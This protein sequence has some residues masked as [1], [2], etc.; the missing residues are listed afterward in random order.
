MHEAVRDEANATGQEGAGSAVHSSGGAGGSGKPTRHER[1][2][3][4]RYEWL[5]IL[6]D[7][8]TALFFIIGSVLFFSPSTVY[9]GTWLFLIG[10]CQMIIGPFIRMFNKLHVRNIR[11]DVVHW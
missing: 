10:S 8:I 1:K 3:H 11:K 4:E 6:N 7:F 5:H 9:D 2:I